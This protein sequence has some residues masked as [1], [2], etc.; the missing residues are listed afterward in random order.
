MRNEIHL[1]EEAILRDWQSKAQLLEDA[2]NLVTDGLLLRGEI[3][4]QDG[5]WYR[6]FG[7]EEKQWQDAK[8]R[9]LILT[10]DLNDTEA[11][12]IRQETGRHNTVAFNYNT[13]I[14]FYK[15]LRMWSYGLLNT[16]ADHYPGFQEAQDQNIV[17]RFY[18]RAP[19]ARV[20]CKKQVGSSSIS[21][22][23]LNLYLETYAEFLKKQ[24][25]L[26]DADII[27]CC[28]CSNEKNIILNFVHAQYL[29]DLESVPDTGDW[30]YYSPS[31]RKIVVNS[32][33]PSARIGYEYTYIEMMSALQKALRNLNL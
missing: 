11:W 28:G 18:E 16:S 15:N 32:Y 14:P 13:A 6:H 23:T 31:S 5:Y 19:I 17:G 1:Q 9:L 26:Y 2:D 24:I 21:D 4:Y 33:H 30:I 8:R 29:P 22:K 27:L 3:Y 12:D 20:N 7:D 10:K 25:A